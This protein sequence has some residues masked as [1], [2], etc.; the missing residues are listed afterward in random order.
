M[1]KTAENSVRI[2]LREATKLLGLERQTIIARVREGVFSCVR[3][4]GKTGKY[5]L[6]RSEV[7]AFL[8][9]DLESLREKP[10]VEATP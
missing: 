9:G 7:E 6:L 1:T 4:K 5:L 3:S 10:A 8:R 2:G